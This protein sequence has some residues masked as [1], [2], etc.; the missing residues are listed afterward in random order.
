MSCFCGLILKSPLKQFSWSLICFQL[1][2]SPQ[3]PLLCHSPNNPWI[4][5]HSS[6]N[7][8]FAIAS[9]C[10]VLW[11][12]LCAVFTVHCAVY[13]LHWVQCTGCS[14][15]WWVM[16]RFI[17]LNCAS[18]PTKHNRLHTAHSQNV[19]CA[20]LFSLSNICF[21]FK[22]LPAKTM[23][24][25]HWLIN[26]C[27]TNYKCT[28]STKT[29]FEDFSYNSKLNL[30]FANGRSWLYEVTQN[31]RGGGGNNEGDIYLTI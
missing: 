4:S 28:K 13:S 27:F 7:A 15:Q 22:Q 1:S 11:C 25:R 21:I 16:R 9:L 31:E 23:N 14:V 5:F 26:N 3:L 20:A 10:T 6:I 24:Q 8:A 17:F 19:R 18:L 12:T 30:N 29:S 2:L